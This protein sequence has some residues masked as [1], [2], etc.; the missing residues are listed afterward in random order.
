MWEQIASGAVTYDKEMSM[1]FKSEIQA[2]R[3]A[4]EDRI[5]AHG[6]T[7][8]EFEFRTFFEAHPDVKAIKW[9]QH[10]YA[11]GTLSVDDFLYSLDATEPNPTREEVEQVLRA[12]GW[13]PNK[14]P[15]ST[16]FWYSQNNT[17]WV[18]FDEE[19]QPP[20][21][22]V[23]GKILDRFRSLTK[24]PVD[25]FHDRYDERLGEL[26]GVHADAFEESVT[27]PE[28]F[29]IVFGTSVEVTATRDGFK[30]RA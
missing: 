28:I 21:A 23:T 30:V 26:F 5:R 7:C 4:T 20:D 27:D 12:H 13:T 24:Q 17:S 6:R 15:G 3:K 19:D 10:T 22:P 11:D 14:N 2:M 9:I 8:L 16:H 1:T 25:G 29:E 18:H